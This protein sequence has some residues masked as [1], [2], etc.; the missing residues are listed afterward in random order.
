MDLPN[1][2]SPAWSALPHLMLWFFCLFLRHC[3]LVFVFNYA[4]HMHCRINERYVCA[5]IPLLGD[6]SLNWTHV[7]APLRNTP[8][9][10]NTTKV[11]ERAPGLRQPP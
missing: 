1:P 4:K 5:L 3:H 9:N 11:F 7:K 6:P 10:L 8:L 2:A